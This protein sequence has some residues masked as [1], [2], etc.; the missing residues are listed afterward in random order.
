[1]IG[2]EALYLLAGLVFAGWALM[3]ALDP[4][5]PRRAGSALFWSGI[6]LSFLAGDALG[7]V[8]N[9]LLVVAL[10]A[11]AATGHPRPMAMPQVSAEARA[12]IAARLGGRLLLAALVVPLTALLGTLLLPRLPFIEA[13]HAT[14][15]SLGL[16]VLLAGAVL[17]RLIATG[18]VAALAAGRGLASQIGW[19]LLL[20]QLLASLGAVFALAG[21]GEIVG[22]GAAAVIPEG[23]RLL[24][25]LAF[26]AGMAAF[27][28]IMGNAFAAFPVMMAAI[29]LPV[30]VVQMGGSPVV[31][32]AV[33]MLAGFCGTLVSPMAA[34]FNIVPAVLLDLDRAAVIRAQA[35]TALPMFLVNT[36]II[37]A[38]AFP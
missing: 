33:G 27:T 4:A 15:L 20:P 19:A 10:V 25:V 5:Q 3:T 30:L 34:N 24:A 38:F 2:L 35:A 13:R 16:G 14:L 28:I 36:A 6:A 29:G 12:A 32:G 21:I 9:G 22:A 18:P 8:G 1:M 23:N 31:I 17:M 7:D 26:T 37:W 11:L